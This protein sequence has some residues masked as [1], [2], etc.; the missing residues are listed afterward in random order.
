MGNDIT[1]VFFLLSG[2]NLVSV[3]YYMPD[4]NFSNHVYDDLNDIFTK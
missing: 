2:L 3:I 4:N 1:I